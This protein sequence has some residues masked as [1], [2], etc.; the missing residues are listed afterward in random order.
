MT[1]PR[2]TTNISATNLVS[3]IAGTLS[4][5][6]SL[7]RCSPH[8]VERAPHLPPRGSPPGIPLP[9]APGGAGGSAGG[10]AAPRPAGRGGR[11]GPEPDARLRTPLHLLLGAGL[12]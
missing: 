1:A 4:F 2:Q 5:Y 3:A 10:G 12:A 9:P 11:A 6:S 7:K 8:E